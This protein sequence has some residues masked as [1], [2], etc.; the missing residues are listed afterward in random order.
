MCQ[1][2][3]VPLILAGT[4]LHT[5]RALRTRPINCGDILDL[6]CWKGLPYRSKQEPLIERECAGNVRISVDSNRR[7]VYLMDP[8]A[9]YYPRAP[10]F[11]EG[12]ELL[13]LVRRDGFQATHAFFEF[14]RFVH[15]G[16]LDGQLIEWKP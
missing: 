14:F 8:G 10:R 1:R 5:I 13:G 15:A 9:W 11:V 3:F 16:R 6:R 12:N 7:T 4:K 2:Q